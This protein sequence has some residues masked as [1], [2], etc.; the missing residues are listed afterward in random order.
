MIM[1]YWLREIRVNKKICLRLI[2]LHNEKE[3]KKYKRK[4]K[5]VREGEMDDRRKKSRRFQS[6]DGSHYQA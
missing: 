4:Q 2:L 6:G 5:S 3:I 1:I